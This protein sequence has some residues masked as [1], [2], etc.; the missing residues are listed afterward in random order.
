[1]IRRRAARGEREPVEPESEDNMEKSRRIQPE[2]QWPVAPVGSLRS[3]RPRAELYGV[4]HEVCYFERAIAHT[5]AG[6]LPKVPDTRTKL[7][8]G[9]HQF[10]AMSH[11]ATLHGALKALELYRGEW[12]FSVPEGYRAFMLAVD[13]CKTT[14]QLILGLHVRL[15]A[16]LARGYAALLRLADP[17]LDGPL[18]E[19]VLPMQQENLR[20]LRWARALP[21]RGRDAGARFVNT[22]DQLWADRATSARLSLGDWLWSPLDRVPKA[23]RPGRMKRA[24]KGSMSSRGHR[25]TVPKDVAMTFHGTFDDEL[26]TME[27]FARCSYEHPDMPLD[28]HLNMARQVSD[29]SRH[30]EACERVCN[31]AG[32]AYG[33]FEIS[34]GV[35]DF[36]YQFPACEAGSKRE[37][38]WR[39]LL[40]ST[41]QEALSLDGFVLQIKKREFHGQVWIARVLESIMAD[42]VFHV[43]SGVRWTRHLC[44]GD[45]ARVQAER[46]AAHDFYIEYCGRTR[47]EFVAEHPER[48]LRELDYIRRRDQSVEAEYP[49]SLAIPVNRRARVAAGFTES[50]LREVVDW[51]YAHP[52]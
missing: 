5:L 34:T 23:K 8:L 9:H 13:G 7:L 15:R 33:D 25:F 50:E 21:R 14:E 37:L 36:H 27:L 2:P 26:T 3:A 1:V 24:T 51:G 35:Y 30:A 20:Q 22:L 18:V 47:A 4:V 39:L 42:E 32:F 29:E 31:E 19:R 44:D 40:R 11:A 41:L 46:A 52:A 45:V 6:W 17:V 43:K 10:A 49:F 38:L 48:A 28:F 12:D 16:H